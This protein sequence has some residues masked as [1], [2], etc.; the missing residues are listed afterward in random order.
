MCGDIVGNY[1]RGNSQ[2][3]NKNFGFL[4]EGTEFIREVYATLLRVGYLLKCIYLF[5]CSELHLTTFCLP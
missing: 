4:R 5:G 1:V 2:C 3:R